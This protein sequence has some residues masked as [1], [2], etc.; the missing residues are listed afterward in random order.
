MLSKYEITGFVTKYNL[1]AV[2]HLLLEMIISKIDMISRQ[3]QSVIDALGGHNTSDPKQTV[4][5]ISWNNR[6]LSAIKRQLFDKGSPIFVNLI[7]ANTQVPY[8]SEY[9]DKKVLLDPK[10]YLPNLKYQEVKSNHPNITAARL[11]GAKIT[12]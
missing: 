9:M 5:Y 1:T 12:C 8:G 10:D 3:T 11:L 6:E 4:D 7:A 2:D